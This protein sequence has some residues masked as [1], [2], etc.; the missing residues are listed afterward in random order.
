MDTSE[1]VGDVGRKLYNPEQMSPQEQNTS[2]NDYI[3]GPCL[4]KISEF[5]HKFQFTAGNSLPPFS[6][7]WFGTLCNA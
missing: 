5:W 6:A 3:D 2:I 1:Y 7:Y 4:Q